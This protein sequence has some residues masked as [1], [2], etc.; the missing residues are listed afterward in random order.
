MISKV[1]FVFRL[2][3]SVQLNSS[4]H[5]LMSRCVHVCVLHSCLAEPE[6][7]LLAL[8]DFSDRGDFPVQG[9]TPSNRLR[10]LLA[11]RGAPSPW[12]NG[13]F[14]PVCWRAGWEE[15]LGVQGKKLAA[16]AW[17]SFTVEERNCTRHL[18]TPRNWQLSTPFP[19]AGLEEYITHMKIMLEA[20]TKGFQ[21][22][23]L[24]FDSVNG[25][26]FPYIAWQWK[27][28]NEYVLHPNGA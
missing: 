24:K 21:K 10:S 9:H 22:L 4:K 19:W 20:Q 6:T 11:G 3:W 1:D 28:S 14:Q 2:G 26:F 27:H 23:H 15:R 13:T 7:Q 8:I 12:S 17:Q 18:Q 25:V 16:S 5:S